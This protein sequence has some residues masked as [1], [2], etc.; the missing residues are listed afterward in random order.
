MSQTPTLRLL[1][2]CRECHRQYDA[3]DFAPGSRFHCDCG[4]VL[5]VETTVPREA[6]VVRCSSCGAPRQSNAAACGFCA[7][8]F[9]LHEQDLNTLCPVCA[10]RISNTA[11]FCHS[12]ATPIAPQAM[13]GDRT[14]SACPSCADSQLLY[15]RPLDG[16]K[17][18]ILECHGCAGIWIGHEVFQLLEDKALEK[19]VGWNPLR[20]GGATEEVVIPS[21]DGPLYRRCPTC[22]Q[23]MNRTNYGRR[24]GVIV[25]ICHEHGVWFDHGELA[26]ILRWIRDGSWTKSERQ[27]ILEDADLEAAR[28]VA[29]APM[30]RTS[31]LPAYGT[32]PATLARLITYI[33]HALLDR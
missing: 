2:A 7:S 26:R 31:T 23:L 5:T 16:E 11:R 1:V 33:L 9:T 18:S 6:A 21:P 4:E 28:R 13:A 8:D 20:P 3:S 22:S 27:K 19:E 17:L 29:R 25:D 30:R 14:D 32:G 12:C 10:T 24:S 15:S